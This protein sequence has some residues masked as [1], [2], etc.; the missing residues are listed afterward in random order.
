MPAESVY[1]T[2]NSMCL[3][4]CFLCVCDSFC[5]RPDGARALEIA[6]DAGYPILAWALLCYG[7]QALPQW[8]V[9]GRPQQLSQ[10][11]PPTLTHEMRVSNAIQCQYHPW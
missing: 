11:A 9:S 4:L 5:F 1:A 2:V 6:A 10:D 7:A 8:K 3:T